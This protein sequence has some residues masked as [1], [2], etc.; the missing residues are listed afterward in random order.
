MTVKILRFRETHAQRVGEIFTLATDRLRKSKGGVYPDKKMD[1]WAKWA[2]NPK[3]VIGELK[4]AR[5]KLL[6][7]EVDGKIVGM[8]GHQPGELLTSPRG[9]T[10]IETIGNLKE[11]ARFRW[12]FVDPEFQGRGIGRIL[13]DAVIE[14]AKKEGFIHAYAYVILSAHGVY[15]KLGWTHTPE[16]DSFTTKYPF[17][18]ELHRRTIEI[19]SHIPR[20]Q[21]KSSRSIQNQTREVQET[22]IEETKLVLNIPKEETILQR[23]DFFFVKRDL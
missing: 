16:H 1:E 11:F 7:A 4:E 18:P 15:E 6:L 20:Q 13:N 3:E 17:D 19:C 14:E 10:N 2:M 12:L 22:K 5:I 21:K 8:F 9:E 23:V